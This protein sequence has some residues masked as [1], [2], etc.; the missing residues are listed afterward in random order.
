MTDYTR[1]E[2]IAWCIEHHADFQTPIFPPPPGWLWV[3]TDG[4][5]LML[6]PIF[7]MTNQGDG[8]TWVDVAQLREEARQRREGNDG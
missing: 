3:E 2:A 1:H 7:T 8:I 4:E 6:E 5:W